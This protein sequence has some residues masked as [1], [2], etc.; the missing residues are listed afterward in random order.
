MKK[1]TLEPTLDEQRI[2]GTQDQINKAMCDMS[3]RKCQLQISLR[4]VLNDDQRKKLVEILRA[5]R[6]SSG[7]PGAGP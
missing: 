5:R 7:Q 1:L 3:M 2:L 6:A 4:Q